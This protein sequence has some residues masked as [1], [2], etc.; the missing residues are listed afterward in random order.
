VFEIKQEASPVDRFD[1]EAALLELE[2]RGDQ[3]QAGRRRQ[4]GQGGIVPR[5]G[6][7]GRQRTF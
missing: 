6:S 2:Q 5:F 4:E 1:Q 3:H 7:C